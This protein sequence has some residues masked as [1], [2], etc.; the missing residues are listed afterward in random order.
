MPVKKKKPIS[1]Y[2]GIMAQQGA[3]PKATATR[4]QINRMA[5]TITALNQKN[6]VVPAPSKTVKTNTESTHTYS[7]LG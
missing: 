7:K 4:E 5:D 2:A 1:H 6:G 3:Q